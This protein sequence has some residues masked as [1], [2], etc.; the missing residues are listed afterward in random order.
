MTKKETIALRYYTALTEVNGSSFTDSD[1]S[2]LASHR[3][4]AWL[5]EKAAEAEKTLEKKRFADKKKA[6]FESEEGKAALETL[7]NM[8]E[9]HTEDV[10]QTEAAAETVIEDYLNAKYSRND[11]MAQVSGDHLNLGIRKIESDRKEF[12]F[13]HDF[14]V[15]FNLEKYS[16][17]K[18]KTE[19]NFGTM[20]C[21]EP[22]VDTKYG[23]RM[24]LL[25]DF[26]TDLSLTDFCREAIKPC[27]EVR[28]N[29][30]P[31]SEATGAWKEDPFNNPKPWEL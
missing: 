21:F 6:Y 9:N 16:F 11:I 17:H 2:Y 25:G 19:I 26:S 8:W 12:I 10:L 4:A 29:Y 20:G 14:T 27:M 23:F 30:A 15:Y 24:K 28:E 18:G 31:L 5:E 1:V 13:G 7:K 22:G 3:S